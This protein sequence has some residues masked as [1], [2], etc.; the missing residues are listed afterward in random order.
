MRTVSSRRSVQPRC[1]S[2][3]ALASLLLV[4]L[5]RG[6]R[7]ISIDFS[8]DIRPILAEQCFACH[9]PDAGERKAELRL[10]THEGALGK[11]ESGERAIVPGKSAE[12]EVV[13]RILSKD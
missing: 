7:L 6:E 2:I 5:A 9:G 13:R 11:G 3:F 12:S 10:D 4:T 8:R 1:L